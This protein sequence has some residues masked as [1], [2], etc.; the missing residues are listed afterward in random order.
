MSSRCVFSLLN[1]SILLISTTATK[2]T[3]TMFSLLVVIPVF[4]ICFSA[5][6]LL[7]FL[8]I[9]FPFLLLLPMTGKAQI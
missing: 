5:A 6:F 2:K 9:N 3:E 8:Y 4:V 7:S 1:P